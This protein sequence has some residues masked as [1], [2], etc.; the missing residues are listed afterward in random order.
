MKRHLLHSLRSVVR[1]PWKALVFFVLIACVTAIL[2]LGLGAYAAG[3][4]AIAEGDAN[5]VTIADFQFIGDNYPD[6]SVADEEIADAIT[7]FPWEEVR[8][9]PGV[10][11][12]APALRMTGVTSEYT[13]PHQ[14]SLSPYRNYVVLI[15]YCVM[16]T[17]SFGVESW[18]FVL[19]QALFPSDFQPEDKS[20]FVFLDDSMLDF[21]FR[22]G[23]TYAIVGDTTIF[24]VDR[25]IRFAGLQYVSEAAGIETLEN[26][27]DITDYK[28]EFLENLPADYQKFANFLLRENAG[29]D[30]IVTG[31]MQTLPEFHQNQIRGSSEGRC[32]FTPEEVANAAKVCVITQRIADMTGL[33]VG[34]TI[35]MALFEPSTTLT[36]GMRSSVS[37]DAAYT[38]IGIVEPSEQ[39]M[40]GN[41][42]VPGTQES[43]ALARTNGYSF[44]QAVL[45]NGQGDAFTAYMTPLLPARARINIYDQGYASAEKAFLSAIQTGAILALGSLAAFLIV[46]AVFAFLFAFRQ[47]ESADNMLTLGA[48]SLWVRAYLCFGA[49][50]L[51]ALAAFAGALAGYF[52][53]GSLNDILF[54]RALN[55]WDSKYSDS[56]LGMQKDFL[57]TIPK[58]PAYLFLLAILD[59]VLCAVLFLLFFSQRAISV[60]T[61]AKKVKRKTG[62]HVPQKER[63][64]AAARGGA[65]K[66]AWLSLTRGGVS[67]FLVSFGAC[68]VLAVFVCAVNSAAVRFEQQQ[69]TLYD[70]TVLEGSFTNFMGNSITNSFVQPETVDILRI[71]GYVR[72][73]HTVSRPKPVYPILTRG[74]NDY[75]WQWIESNFY[76]EMYNFQAIHWDKVML[77]D[78]LSAAQEFVN[79]SNDVNI[80]WAPGWDM[81]RF[82][83]QGAEDPRVCL[84]S[85]RWMQGK[86]MDVNANLEPYFVDANGAPFDLTDEN[87]VPLPYYIYMQYDEEDNF[88]YYYIEDK[89]GN[90][91]TFTMVFPESEFI[92]VEFGVTL[93]LGVYTHGERVVYYPEIIGSFRTNGVM[94]NVYFPADQALTRPLK[95]TR[96]TKEEGN[97]EWYDYVPFYDL[98][99]GVYFTLE[100][101]RDLDAFK[102]FLAGNDFGYPGFYGRRSFV[103]IADRNFLETRSALARQ[104]SYLENI[105]VLLYGLSIAVSLFLAYLLISGRR[106]ELALMKSVGTGNLRMFF[107]F[108]WE[109]CMLALLAGGAGLLLCL[110]LWQ[111]L[112][113]KGVLGIGIVCA[114]YIAGCAVSIAAQCRV[115][116]RALFT[117]E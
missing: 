117:D 111:S 19:E 63:R 12:V 10:V 103:F 22:R 15:M 23:H 42:Y 20:A 25:T 3:N 72:E 56:A 62:G 7:A 92:P 102:E 79:S 18:G 47:R 93:P 34:D 51:A 76:R 40:W 48:K 53:S 77:L 86:S 26:I 59:A 106:T 11:S 66:Y 116:V 115:S 110:A 104:R 52:L 14:W 6:A 98:Y 67:R 41:I 94:D 38:I 17:T 68:L 28:Y 75:F 109:Q 16:P 55:P 112:P 70:S 49:G 101:A 2:F 107:S 46:L 87:G 1:A 32:S 13:T 74:D 80:S 29:L 97:V 71:S 91:I 108:F 9:A 89:E 21:D 36:G 61:S 83:A 58:V 57:Q 105:S 8:L 33:L 24:G 64:S 37:E 100:D 88:Q 31:D 39:E 45:K 44:G 69:E 30:V 95:R 78:D 60:R 96:Y 81:E 84:V 113:G 73:V 27:L 65:L 99:N 43:Y 85:E 90:Q 4:I 82:A 35:E 54:A 5:Y 50:V 114:C